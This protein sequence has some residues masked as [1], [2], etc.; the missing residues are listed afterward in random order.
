M[1]GVMFLLDQPGSII[2]EAVADVER[3]NQLNGALKMSESE[4]KTAKADL[5]LRI[6]DG[7]TFK[8]RRETF[9]GLDDVLVDVEKLSQRR[10][11]AEKVASAHRNLVRLGERYTKAK[12]E[13]TALEGL[14]D[15]ES[16]LP[17][18]KRVEKAKAFRH[19]IGLTVDLAMRYEAAKKD[20]QTA[21][22]AQDAV[23]QI[24]LDA[25]LPDQADR[26]MRALGRTKGLRDR[27]VDAQELVA[28]LDLQIEQREKELAEVAATATT[29]LGTFTDCPTCG[30]AL[31]HVH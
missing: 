4:R 2:A 16:K 27:L 14:D 23:A 19:A 20:H 22:A 28:N 13:V 24:A 21:Q 5:K 3:V 30:G 31:D 26:V 10:D 11:K 15:V 25:T 18:E 1:N 9:N 8:E 6:K 29:L 12:E 17:S 7:K